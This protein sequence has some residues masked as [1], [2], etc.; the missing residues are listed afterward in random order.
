MKLTKRQAE[1]LTWIQRGASNKQIAKTL[2]ITESTVKIHVSRLLKLYAVRSRQQL[3]IYS[4]KNII[5]DLP[6]HVEDQPFG[7]VHRHGDKVMGIIFTKTQPKENWEAI[8][9]KRKD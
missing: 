3:A 6:D 7:W 2:N 1:V 9:L 4:S 5:I 8:Y